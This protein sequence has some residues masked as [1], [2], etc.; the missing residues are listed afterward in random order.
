MTPTSMRFLPSTKAFVKWVVPIMTHRMS[1]AATPELRKTSPIA[2]RMPSLTFAVVGDLHDAI[3]SDPFI[4]A[5]SVLVPPTSMPILIDSPFWRPVLGESFEV[6]GEADA[7]HARRAEYFDIARGAV[8]KSA[9][10]VAP[11]RQVSAIEHGFPFAVQ[12]LYTEPAVPHPIRRFLKERGFVD[13]EVLPGLEMEISL[14]EPVRVAALHEVVTGTP[15][16][17]PRRRHGKA[18]IDPDLLDL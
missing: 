17:V 10:P 14:N 8:R 1:A 4:R 13:I 11:V 15:V 6:V 2:L 7:V 9:D 16:G 12:R 5:A 18:A 3:S